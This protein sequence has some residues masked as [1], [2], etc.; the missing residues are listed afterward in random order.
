MS[1]EMKTW[2]WPRVRRVLRDL[3][4]RYPG[5][6]DTLPLRAVITLCP[7]KY[8]RALAAAFSVVKWTPGKVLRNRPCGLCVLYEK[9][10]CQ[11]CKVCPLCI[12]EGFSCYE[13]ESLYHIAYF[14]KSEEA[15]RK[16]YAELCDIYKNEYDKLLVEKSLEEAGRGTK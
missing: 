7:V 6:A 2:T 13:E 4:E 12:Q 10:L 16:L 3:P 15:A 5:Y 9:I 11:N 1:T 8:R 14:E